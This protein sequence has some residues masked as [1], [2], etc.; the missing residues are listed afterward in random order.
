M[1]TNSKLQ[2]IPATSDNANL[3]LSLQPNSAGLT[4]TILSATALTYNPFSRTLSLNGI[5]W[6]ASD[7]TAGQ[8]LRTDGAGNL[9]FATAGGGAAT[10]L[11]ISNK[12]G[13][14][15][16]IASDAGTIINCTANSFTVSLTAAATL[17]AG[18]N[19]TIWNTSSVSTDAITID[20]AGS[21]TVGGLLTLI[22]RRG[23]GTQI[24]CDGTNWQTGNKKTM[25]HYAENFS[26]A[27]TGQSQALGD[28]SVA[29]M[30]GTASGSESFA[31]GVNSSASATN[32][33]AVGA[34]SNASSNSSMAL[35]QNS[36]FNGSQAV[37][38]AGAMALGGSYA[39]GSDSFA[40]AV[41]NNTSSYGAQGSNS[42]AIGHLGRASGANACVVGGGVGNSAGANVSTGAA[43]GAYGGTVTSYGLLLG[44]DSGNV[45]ADKAV[46][47]SGQSASATEKG[48]IVFGASVNFTG[49][50]TD[51]GHVQS[52]L[53][54]L[55]ALTTTATP[56]VLTSDF[57]AAGTS[58]QVILPNNSAFAFSGT[59]VARRQAAGGT[60][61]AAWQVEGLIR[62]E[63]NAAS[64]VLV[65]SSI[66]TISNVPNWTLAITANTT[67]GSLTFTATGAAATN[68]RWVATI[69]TSEVIYA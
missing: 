35:G 61:S 31:L 19:V 33:I 11:V 38:G 60:Q 7:G 18:F 25:R 29:M 13:A 68:I 52:G 62:R 24:I 39:S 8:V 27:A 3:F 20:P 53:I 66:N 69:Q 36:G 46:V 23:E 51:L 45:T 16:V 63:A 1:I 14:Y 17:G 57:L 59:I 50:R 21:E 10:P 15:T 42:V 4:N 28:S 32:A 5:R 6:P 43:F 22:I 65:S 58:N 44:G 12:T 41:G 37:T 9:T 2:V 30:R 64:T 48:K 67:N 40:A 34:S 56:S 54:V 47:I 26:A 49:F 55:L